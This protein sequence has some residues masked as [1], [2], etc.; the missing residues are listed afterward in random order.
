ML[1][2]DPV[3]L[4]TFDGS[5]RTVTTIGR[6][7]RYRHFQALPALCTVRGGGY[8]YSPASFAPDRPVVTLKAFNR[9]LRFDPQAG[10][11]EVEAGITL[12]RLLGFLAPRGYWCPVI[13]GY[14]GITVGGCIAGDV[15]GK[16]HA[17]H[18][19][20]RHWVKR[21][22]LAGGGAE[23]MACDR[24]QQADLF[25]LTCG[26]L[27]LTGP[28]VRATLRVVP[29]AGGQVATHRQPV[30]DLKEGYANL[31]RVGPDSEFAYSWHRPWCRGDRRFGPG[32]VFH[33]STIAGSPLP[34]ARDFIFAP[35]A[36]DAEDRR[37]PIAL[38]GG[39]G[40]WRTRAIYVAAN[41]LETSKEMMDDSL[42]TSLF[43]FV[44]QARYFQLFGRPGLQEVQVLVA[45]AAAPAFIDELAALS[46]DLCPPAAVIALKL[47][48]GPTE[49]IR[50]D[51]TG[52]GVAIDLVRH[53]A[54]LAFLERFDRICVEH[55]ARLN[56]MKDSRLS[57]TVFDACCPGAPAFRQA[58]I[59]HGLK[60]RY[61][62]IL[63]L[64]LGLA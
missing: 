21:L 30:A 50:F 60:G 46:R 34:Q 12:A 58:L 55:Q 29:L 17:V 64:Q 3:T 31:L 27:G 24:T 11:V 18:G 26:G 33:G 42:F 62:S 19:N 35:L 1:P 41:L 16:S 37:L 25:D 56:L 36:P 6:P 47:F 40:N 20:F 32:F 43:P 8:S 38:F 28:I 15:H 54:S 45:H 10:E 39:A 5:H 4:K 63:A 9:I 49:G 22:W 48:H 52:L 13:P 59:Q 7:D 23:F 2:T 57:R 44:D 53:P 61:A 14:P 51:G